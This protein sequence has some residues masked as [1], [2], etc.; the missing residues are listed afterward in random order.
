MA[1]SLKCNN[2]VTMYQFDECSTSMDNIH[3]LPYHHQ[4]LKSHPAKCFRSVSH[5]G[6]CY[7]P[8]VVIA[9]FR[10]IQLLY[11]SLHPVK[12]TNITSS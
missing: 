3:I 2:V 5:G 1:T 9:V 11:V 12:T 7:M 10:V 8:V 6:E 4:I